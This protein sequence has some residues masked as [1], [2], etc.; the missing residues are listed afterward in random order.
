M[1]GVKGFA[2]LLQSFFVERL[3]RQRNASPHTIASYRDSFRLLLSFAQ[4]HLKKPPSDLIINDLDTPFIGAFLEHLEQERNNSARSRNVR[5]AAIHSF[6]RYVMLQEPQHAAIAE[7]VLAMPSKRYIRR[8]VA[9]LAA[10]EVEALL[11]APDPRTWAGHR[12]RTLLLVAVQTGLRASELNGLCCEDAVL[13]TGA[14]LHC[15]GKG[16]KERSTPLRKDAAKALR[17]WLRRRH[18]KPHDPLFP[19]ARGGHLS[20]DGLQYLLN[21]HLNTARQRCPSLVRKKVTPHVLRHTAAMALLQSGVDRAV[22]ALWLG[23]ESVETTYI[24]LHADLK[25]KEQAL[26]KT[27]PTN[28]PPARFKPDDT[29]LSFLNDL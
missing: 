20:H 14:H 23:H 12:D 28:I 8:P 4:R 22:I 17:G 5:L 18:G 7:R 2:T 6:F 29:L 1:T 26:A 13:G 21:K 3:M 15:C 16:R 24:Y 11:A 10:P 9:F 25:L 19:S 27:T